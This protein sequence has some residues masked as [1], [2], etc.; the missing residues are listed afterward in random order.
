MGPRPKRPQHRPVGVRA[1]LCGPGGTAFAHSQFA[2]AHPVRHQTRP[3]LLQL[4]AGRQ[5]CAR[6][7]APHDPGGIQETQP[8]LGDGAGSG[9]IG[10]GGKRELG[11]A[12][13]Q[14]SPA[15][16]RPLPGRTVPRRGRCRRPARIRFD[17]PAI[18]APGGFSVPEAKTDVA[19][20]D[21]DTLYIGTDFGPGSLTTSGYPR[22]I[23]EWRRGTPLSQ[24]RTVFEGEPGDVDAN[25]SV[26]HDHG[27]VY[28]WIRRGA[29]FFHGRS[30][31]PARRAMGA[32]GQAGRCPGG[33][34]WRRFA[35]ALA[36]RLDRRG[37]NLRGRI[38]PGR[39]FDGVSAGPARSG[40][41]VRADGARLP[42]LDHGDKTLFGLDRIGQRPQPALFVAVQ[43]AANGSAR[44]CRRPLS[45]RSASRG[46]TPSE[47]DDY[48]M[49]LTDF[50]TPPSLCLGVA[51]RPGAEKIKSLP[52]FFS[53][54]GLEIRQFEAKSKD[55]AVIPYF[56]VGRKGLKLDGSNITL[57]NGYGGFEIP[58]LPA[59]N[60]AHRRGLA[61]ARRRLCPGQHPRRRRIRPQMA[62]S[63][64]QTKPPAGL[65]RFHRGGGGPDR[66]RRHLAPASGHRRALQ[67]RIAHGRDAH[68][69]A[70]LVRGGALRLAVAGHAPLQQAPGRR[71]LDGRI[72]RSRQAGRL[73]LH[74]KVFPLPE[75]CAPTRSIRPS[76]SPPRRATTGCIPGM[77]ARWRRVCASRA[78][79][80][81]IMKT[82]KA[83]T[84]RRRT[85]SNPPSWKRWP[86]L[87]FGAN[88][89]VDSLAGSQRPNPGRPRCKGFPHK[90]GSRIN[91][92]KIIK[93]P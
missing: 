52:A 89:R 37:Q 79:R 42:G 3:L 36:L 61:G 40:R 23:K 81:C 66:A 15:P 31:S 54:D 68:R 82:S 60:P 2:R 5:K 76:S 55:G 62:R 47:S 93:T 39:G 18:H 84:A 19:W 1:G 83:V 69:A 91:V 63:G 90:L 87:S 70:G 32:G 64:A 78:T 13:L 28:E 88:F 26:D 11:L 46:S 72:R 22:V 59:Y 71:Q 12:R 20:R 86:T 24:A 56:Q 48:F 4:L 9:P 92:A 53:A 30:V 17:P 38:A 74:P 77:P 65:R 80:F 33:D 29:H 27:R 67:R 25:V 8:S 21:R 7:V 85:T 50:L 6:A 75:R 45:G 34:V 51:G 16:L 44:R 58:M 73:G 57:L 10:R 49:R 43:R 14:R 41:A 35:P